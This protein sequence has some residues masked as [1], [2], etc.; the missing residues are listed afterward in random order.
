[1]LCEHISPTRRA[2]LGA[3]G[4]LFAW[5]FM[6]RF[7]HAA[8]G[9]DPRFVTIILRGALDGLTAVPPIGDP[10]YEALRQ[11]S[12]MRIDGA[13]PALPLDGFFALHPSMRNFQRL[14][15]SG[16][17]AVV[18]ASATAYRDRSHFDGQDV[19]ESGFPSPGHVETGWLNRLLEGLPPGERVAPGAAERVR[20][21]SV[22]TTAALLIRGKAPVLGWAP[23]ILKPADGDLAPRLADLYGQKDPVL[24][25]LLQEGIDTGKIASGIDIK[26]RGGPGDPNGMEQ[27]ARGAAR[28]IAHP[29]GPRVAALAFEGWDTHAQETDR[30]AKL[31]TG[32]DNA[33]AAFEQE[34]GPV[35]KDTAILVATEF[36]RTARVNGT[37]GTDHGT[38]TTAFLAGGAIRGGRVITDWP[39][40]KEAQ[41]R[42]GRDLAPTTDI[43]AIIKGVATDLLGANAN[44]LRDVVFPGSESVQAVKGLIV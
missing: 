15:R 33:L 11:Q 31:L 29:E 3:S 21:L 41:L 9:R 43:R 7:A 42:D 36:G 30:L 13:N 14:F 4:A 12:A 25:R 5:A 10:D 8:G 37:E 17:A 38:G 32:L 20:G 39:G 24:A 44:H 26:A 6:P 19:L 23:S 27:M 18:H 40:L 2:V 35:W 28:L 34:L 1:M 22:G 16:Q